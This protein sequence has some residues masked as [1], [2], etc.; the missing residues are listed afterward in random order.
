MEEMW[1]GRPPELRGFVCTCN[2]AAPGSNPK[3]S[4]STFF[5]YIVEIE[6]VIDVEIRNG[7]I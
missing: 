2:S 1:I 3:Y 6:T 7:R 4:I 5:I